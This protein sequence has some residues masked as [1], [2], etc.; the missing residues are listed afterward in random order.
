MAAY[1]VED[2]SGD[3]PASSTGKCEYVFAFTEDLKDCVLCPLGYFSTGQCVA[4]A[5]RNAYPIIQTFTAESW[6]AARV[7]ARI[8]RDEFEASL[9][10]DEELPT[11]G[12]HRCTSGF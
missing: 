6:D 10:E 5:T 9:R 4:F 7:R 11:V 1:R 3:D 2:S 12:N 8:L